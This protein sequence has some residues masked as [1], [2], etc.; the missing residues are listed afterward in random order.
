M[1]DN[2]NYN[3]EIEEEIRRPEYSYIERWINKEAKV[4]DLGCGNGTLL[5]FLKEKKNIFGF[6]I[7]I[8]ETGVEISKKKGLNTR[9]G[10]IDV[11]LNDIPDDS[12]DFAICNV[13][14]QMVMYPEMTLKEMK[15]IAKY[16][17]VSFPNFAFFMNRLELL[18]KGHMPKTLLYGYEWY[19][20]GHIHQLSI[21]DFKDLISFLDLTIKDYVYSIRGKKF[22]KL[23]LL[24]NWFASM[25]IFLSEK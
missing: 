18:V 12:F 4:I 19:N 8:S 14:L 11:R 21:K 7:D 5:S 3:W 20:T 24:P 9:V 25:A 6:G 16:Q 13:T 22:N 23:I 10:R 15:R 2:R 17:I 1:R